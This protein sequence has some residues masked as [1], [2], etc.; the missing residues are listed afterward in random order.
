MPEPSS[1]SSA[2]PPPITDSLIL[3]L[4][5]EANVTKGSDDKV[6]QWRDA[7]TGLI[8]ADQ[9]AAAAKPLWVAD[10]FP[11]HPGIR[12]SGSQSLFIMTS[13]MGQDSFTI[14]ILGRAAATRASGGSTHAGQRF[15]ICQNFTEGFPAVSV[16]TNGLGIYEFGTSPALRAEALTDAGTLC[17]LTIRYVNRA[18]AAYLGGSL[19][20]QGAPTSR[21]LC[22]IPHSIG[23]DGAGNGFVGDIA[24]ILIYSGTFTDQ[25]RLVV[26][27][28]LQAKY[29]CY[30]SSSDSSESSE[31]SASSESSESSGGGGGGGSSDSS[32]SSDSSCSESSDSSSSESSDSSSSESSD[33]SSSESSDSSSS[34]SSDS[35]SSESSDSS[36]S[37]ESSESSISESSDTDEPPTV[38]FAVQ[39]GEGKINQGFDPVRLPSDPDDEP[40]WASVGVESINEVVKLVITPAEG[41]ADVELRVVE[42]EQFLSIYPADDFTESETD[43]TLSGVYASEITEATVEAVSKL[44]GEVLATLKVM[45]L[46]PQIVELGIYRVIDPNSPDTHDVGGMENDAI[47]T[48]LNE[49]YKQAGISFSLV[50]SGTVNA[51]YDMMPK[52]GR[53]QIENDAWEFGAV[54]TQTLAG[55]VRLFL[56]KQSGGVYPTHPEYYRRALVINDPENAAILFVQNIGEPIDLVAAHEIGHILTIPVN[57]TG[58][59]DHDEDPWPNGTD[60][61][62]KSGFDESGQPIS[63]PGKWMRHKD[64]KNANKAAS[65]L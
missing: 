10:A 24:E 18:P 6:S 46:P 28:W 11:G 33:S 26:E 58:M 45:V 9:S 44:T 31:S 21:I 1:S 53:M 41:A 7:L 32:E 23:G 19:V 25:N 13:D 16:G 5:A 37:S 59:D 52:D 47:V 62:M 4:T 63:A 51:N 15:L 56:V 40:V 39:D 60:G 42:G 48:S 35:S 34:E 30:G 27:S 49:I 20:C 12:F 2:E 55:T 65:E 38:K 29:D 50:G 22:S 3:W 61:L 57:D 64:W 14:I 43:L 36:G 8:A 54:Q 17:P